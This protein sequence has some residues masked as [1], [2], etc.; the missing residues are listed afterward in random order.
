MAF[1]ITGSPF[2]Y[3]ERGQSFQE[4]YTMQAAIQNQV[5]TIAGNPVKVFHATRNIQLEFDATVH[6]DYAVAYAYCEDNQRLSELFAHRDDNKLPDLYARLPMTRG[7][8]SVACGDWMVCVLPANTATPADIREMHA[9]AG[10][11]AH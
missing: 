2:A 6:P 9:R 4:E 3:T 11:L 10:A 1:F 7:V 8:R 5:P